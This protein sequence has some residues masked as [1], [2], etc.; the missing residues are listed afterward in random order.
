MKNLRSGFTK[1]YYQQ[2]PELSF[3]NIW[4]DD[5]LNS[6]HGI[7]IGRI[8][9]SKC[10]ECL[11]LLKWINTALEV[12]FEDNLCTEKDWASLHNVY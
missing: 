8:F 4:P 12:Y 9:Q 7:Y 2:K 11:V 5:Y 10:A 6:V 1:S 3:S